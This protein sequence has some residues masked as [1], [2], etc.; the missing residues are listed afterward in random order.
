MACGTGKT[1]TAL[2]IAEDVVPENGS[3]L[4]MAPSIALV[5]RAREEWLTHAMNRMGTVVICSDST[6]GRSTSEDI[7]LTELLSPVTTKPEKIAQTMA[8]AK[9]DSCR[10]LYV[11]I[12]RTN[13]R[14]ATAIWTG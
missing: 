14:S 1:F 7:S 10:L 5:S 8:R 11:P 6:A 3:I 9:G 12:L 4:F 2:R 13:N